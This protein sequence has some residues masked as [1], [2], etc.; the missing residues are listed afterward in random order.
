MA[1]AGRPRLR[2]QPASDAVGPVC[3]RLLSLKP[4]LGILQTLARLADSV[5]GACE[6][7]K[8]DNSKQHVWHSRLH[9]VAWDESRRG[10]G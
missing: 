7:P 9:L 4:V 2:V 5:K 8:M 3:R 1:Q 10:K 6:K